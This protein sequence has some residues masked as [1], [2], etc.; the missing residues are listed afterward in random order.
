MMS[1]AR[2]A[3]IVVSAGIFYG[4]EV[5][6]TSGRG[7]GMDVVRANVERVG[8]VVELESQEGEGTRLRMRVPLTLAIVPALVVQ[9]GG[10]SF[11]M[12]QSA[13]GG[14]DCGDASDEVR[15]I[16]SVGDVKMYRLREELLP[17]VWLSDLLGLP[18]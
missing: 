15:L 5:T 11:A 14:V 6:L 4:D 1:E 10:G 18:H 3:A 9:S 8:G 13:A 16:Q 12:P 2:G 7:V 17:L